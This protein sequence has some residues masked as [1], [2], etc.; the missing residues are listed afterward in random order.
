MDE[1]VDILVTLSTFGVNSHEPLRLLQESGFTFRVNPYRRRMEPRE[2]VQLGHECRG[3]VAGVEQYTAQTLSELPYLRC[4]SRAG[5]GIDNI[6]VAE[7]QRRGIAVLNTPD[8]P[9]IAVAELTLTMMLALLRQLPN[10]DSLMHRRTWERVQGHLLAGKTVGIIGLGRI[11]RRVAELVQAFG[12]IVIGVEP[13][14]DREWV[15]AHRVALMDL[16]A[17]LS[18]ADIVSVHATAS[19]DHPL[20]L[21][22]AELAQMKRGAWL[23]NMARGDMVD[24]RA[25]DKALASG[26][27]SGAAL[28]VFPE[29]PYR[30][31]LCDNP[32]VILSPHQATLTP[33]TRTAMETRAVDNL[34]HYLRNERES[35]C[36]DKA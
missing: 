3:L 4:I 34:I 13:N 8:E 14:P 35:G 36:V 10:V 20:H 32:G 11:G 15:R 17:L 6:D 24:D 12:A 33:E 26:S 16:P 28:D 29:E 23:I 18:R 27:L 22:V 5:A 30:G 2:V 7:A 25:L 31:P 19:R 1:R 9:T 21:G